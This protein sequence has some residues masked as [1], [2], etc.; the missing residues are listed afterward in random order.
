MTWTKI[1]QGES[2]ILLV[3]L[4]VLWR[5]SRTDLRESFHTE[6]ALKRGGDGGGGSLIR[7]IF[8]LGFYCTKWHSHKPKLG[9]RI[10]C[11][12]EVDVLVYAAT[13]LNNYEI[14]SAGP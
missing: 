14:Q 6:S 4:F 10:Q 2:I 11:V 7:V 1:K 12:L 8:V 5:C 3:L 13:Q 9:F